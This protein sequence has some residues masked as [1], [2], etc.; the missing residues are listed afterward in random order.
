MDTEINYVKKQSTAVWAKTL[1]KQK[2]RPY[3]YYKNSISVY[4]SFRRF[5]TGNK[6]NYTT[7]ERKYWDLFTIKW[8]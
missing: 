8:N 2:R 7:F 3:S 6:K 1:I 5:S 4:N